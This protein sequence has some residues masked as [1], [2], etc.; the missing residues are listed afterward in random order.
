LFFFHTLWTP[1]NLPPGRSLARFT[2]FFAKSR[3]LWSVRIYRNRTWL[4]PS[5]TNKLGLGFTTVE[6]AQMAAAGNRILHKNSA[7]IP[8]G[9][10]NLIPEAKLKNVEKKC[11]A[12][13]GK[14]ITSP[15]LCPSITAFPCPKFMADF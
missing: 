4:T 10:A 12:E 3:L 2:G 14:K 7:K 15:T 8:G 9:K 5:I 11:Q 6:K 1:P 13:L